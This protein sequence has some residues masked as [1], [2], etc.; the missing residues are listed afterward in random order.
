MTAP[1][2]TV[3]TPTYN[4]AH[5]LHR[6]YDSLLAQT[7]RDFEW[8][9]VDDGSI[10]NT[11]ELVKKWQTEASFSIRYI[12]QENKGKHVASNVGVREAEG[13]LFLFFDS[14]DACVPEALERF[15]HHWENI[16]P[17]DRQNFST[18]AVLCMDGN[19]KTI[20]GDY[21]A[22]VIDTD[23]PWGRLSL[24]KG[25]DRWGVNSTDVLKCYPF[26]EFPGE[27]F[28][29]EGVVWNRMACAYKTR[30]VNERLKIV[31]YLH[32]GLSASTV[33]IRANS[34]Q[35]ARLYY[36][37]LSRLSIPLIAKIRA[38][39]NYVRFSC[40]GGIPLKRMVE[41]SASPTAAAILLPIGYLMYK[42]DRRA[43]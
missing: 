32:D 35:G 23:T 31:E 18:L 1:F 40:H 24:G 14:D 36:D 5:T 27:T 10:D 33:R 22:A 11:A 17:V 13:K 30:F 38:H 42:A 16:L 29:T 25:G 19:G 6:V 9:I 3:F 4:R 39:I 41:E 2:F 26:P 15:K 37:E 21:P 28:I 12:F 8:L 20:G 34:P 43:L 7:F